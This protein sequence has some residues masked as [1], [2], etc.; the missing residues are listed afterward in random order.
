M[1]FIFPIFLTFHII[2]LTLVVGTTVV[3]FLTSLVFWK[4]LKEKTEKAF[5]TYQVMSK[6]PAL[7]GIGAL[8]IIL[9]GIGM[10]VSVNGVF[11]E[12]LWFKIKFILLVLWL[13]NGILIGKKTAGK[14]GKIML[15]NNPN[16]TQQINEMKPGIIR[17]YITQFIIFF[18][19]ILLSVF[20]FN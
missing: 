13:L 6:F 20:K 14:I 9:S 19:I 2:G 5:G 16:C 18:L 7:I 17:F 15:T 3:D 4:Q 8:L 12:Q 10:M 1:Q 11:A